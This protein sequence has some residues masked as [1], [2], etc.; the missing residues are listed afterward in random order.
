MT[1][2]PVPDQPPPHQQPIQRTPLLGGAPS[3]RQRPGPLRLGRNVNVAALARV[4]MSAAR[5][6]AGVIVPV[7]L[8]SV[9]YSALRL[10]LLFVVAGVASAL[11]STAVG[12]LSDRLG[13]KAFMV[14]VPLLATLG[15]VAFALTL[16][17]VAIFAGAALGSF[18]RGG[19]AGGGT[20][21]PYAP[22]EQALVAES[23]PAANRNSAFGWLGFGTSVGAVAGSAVVVGLVPGHPSAAHAM[24]AYRPAFVALAA[25]AFLA[26]VLGL[27]LREI[28]PSS[29]TPRVR[30]HRPLLPRASRGLLYRLW[31]T[32]AI[33]GTAV[34]MFGPFVSYWFYRRFGM[35][36]GTI[37][38]LYAIINASTTVA[39]LAAPSVA[40]RLGLI[41]SSTLF[42]IAQS[43][44]LVPMVLAPSF[45]VAG[46][47]YLVRMMA[48]RASMPLRQSY[49]MAQSDPAERARVA[50]LAQL[51]SQG[52]TAA[53][54]AAAG[55]L[56]DHVALAAPFLAGAALQLTNAIVYY[57]FFRRRP[58]EEELARAAGSS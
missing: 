9:G 16:N 17:P 11:L 19:G 35:G 36:A 51:P 54:P 21:G 58:P 45:A 15:G 55:E 31:I 29:P 20:V 4:S 3:R 56:F 26:S 34:G 40:R 50:A 18:G 43:V 6:L 1:E 32:N 46:A 22:A 24:A 53:S 41:R 12:F 48:Q 23:V 38:E 7:Y 44:L 2:E 25:C 37:G 30:S 52:T 8:A 49:V 47:I 42:R 27:L 33:N 13:R 57:A 14:A 28:P 39:N 10:G 5:A